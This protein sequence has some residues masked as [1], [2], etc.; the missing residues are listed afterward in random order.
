MCIQTLNP[1]VAM[2]AQLVLESCAY[3]GSGNVL[4]VQQFLSA[5]SEHIDKESDE[6]NTHGDSHQVISSLTVVKDLASLFG[7]LSPCIH[8]HVILLSW[9]S[10]RA[11]ACI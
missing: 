8:G 1:K 2:Y 7:G 10:I 5:C 9:S 11:H 4:K 3:C 6:Y